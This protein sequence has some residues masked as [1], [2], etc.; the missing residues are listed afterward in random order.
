M[1]A[2][3][4]EIDRLTRVE[5]HMVQKQRHDDGN[6][7]W[8]G[9]GSFEGPCEFVDECPASGSVGNTPNNNFGQL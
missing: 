5:H 8:K 3:S 6:I 7:A 2:S 1:E 9:C 4:P